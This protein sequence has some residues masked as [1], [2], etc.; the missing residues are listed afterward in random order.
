[1]IIQCFNESWSE[2]VDIIR[3]DEI[4]AGVKYRIILELPQVL[5]AEN[6]EIPFSENT[7]L[8]LSNDASFSSELFENKSSRTSTSYEASFSALDIFSS[9]NFSIFLSDALKAKLPLGRALKSELIRVVCRAITADTKYPSSIR[10]T[11]AARKIVSDYPYL[12]ESMGTGSGGWRQSIRDC[13]KNMRRSDQSEEVKARKKLLK[14]TTSPLQ[15]TEKTEAMLGNNQYIDDL[16]SDLKETFDLRRNEIVDQK[17]KIEMLKQKYPS[18]FTRKELD[19]EFFRITGQKNLFHRVP[20][21]LQLYSAQLH[22]LLATRKILPP[23][24]QSV[25]CM[26]E[27]SNKSVEAIKELFLLITLPIHFGENQLVL[28]YPVSSLL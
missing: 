9:A 27:G 13:L 17:L 14:G 19:N 23:W 12:K 10:I 11:D 18:L 2:Y 15:N 28:T 6:P 8:I 16:Q 25:K 26:L 3:D 7:E 21:F 22:N 4:I 5:Y 24:V 20:N 1:M